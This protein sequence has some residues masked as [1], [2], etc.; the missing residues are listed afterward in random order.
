MRNTSIDVFDTAQMVSDVAALVACDTCYPPGAG[1]A[2][3][4]ETLRD[5]CGD[6][7]GAWQTLEV[8]EELWAVEG[9]SGPRTN[10]ILR[11]ALGSPDAPEALIYFHTDTAPVGQGWTRPALQLTQEGDVLFGRGTADMK[12]TIASVLAALRVLKAT[13]AKLAYRPVLAFC[14]DEEGGRYPGIRYLVETAELPDVLL[15]LN[16]SAEP[17]IWAGCFG[18]LTFR[19]DVLGKAAHS[20]TPERGLNAAEAA[21]PLLIALTELK[22]RIEARES[23]MPARPGSEGPLRPRFSITGV[24]SGGSGSAIPGDCAVTLNRRYMPEEDE[25]RVRQEIEACV[26]QAFQGDT[27][28]RWTMSEVGHLPVVTDPDGPATSRWTA[29]RAEAAGIPPGDFIRYG[30]TASSDFGWVQRAGY[31]HMLLGGLARPTS[32]IHAADEHTT[33]SELTTL[34]RAVQLFL[35]A[36]FDPAPSTDPAPQEGHPNNKE[37]LSP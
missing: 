37:A 33:L 2:A 31:R 12:G 6:L 5:L 16:G 17:R 9:A 19:I 27:K 11:P 36:D 15:N 1:Y 20:G 3:L 21:L 26:A 34:A 32:N 23:A 4:A 14:T 18:S 10:V 8:P 28:V 13:A 35:S 25:A 7:D 29:A 30:S 24:Q 22:K